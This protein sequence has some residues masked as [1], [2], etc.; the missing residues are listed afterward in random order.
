MKSYKLILSIVAVILNSC[1]NFSG[2]VNNVDVLEQTKYKGFNEQR[3]FLLNNLG[4][5]NIYEN[6]IYNTA[7]NKVFRC[8]LNS[9]SAYVQIES[10]GS[11]SNDIANAMIVWKQWKKHPEKEKHE[12]RGRQMMAVI[13]ELYQVKDKVAFF[14]LLTYPKKGGKF[15]SKKFKVNIEVDEQDLYIVRKAIF[16]F[17]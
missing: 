15:V 13:L 12:I 6:D 3:S 2:D 11:K 8:V 4:C 17:S 14:E 5:E 7:D 9:A 16:D 10:A 1:A